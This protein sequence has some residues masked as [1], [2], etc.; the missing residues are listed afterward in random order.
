MS[1][2][3]WHEGEIIS[4]IPGAVRFHMATSYGDQLHT[5]Q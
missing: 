4:A 5:K 1:T 2:P 3:C